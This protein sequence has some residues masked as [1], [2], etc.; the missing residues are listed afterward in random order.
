MWPSSIHSDMWCRGGCSPLHISASARL[1]QPSAFVSL[2]RKQA[3]SVCKLL[4]A[5]GPQHAELR[6]GREWG[7]GSLPA[8]HGLQEYSTKEFNP[9]AF[10]TKE[11]PSARTPESKGRAGQGPTRGHTGERAAGQSAH[12]TRRCRPHRLVPSRGTV[13]ELL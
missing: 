13:N 9:R 12:R 2:C 11:S 3:A 10:M 6:E 7:A 5:P 1:G 4:W 8:P